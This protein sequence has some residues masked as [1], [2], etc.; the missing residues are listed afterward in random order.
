[1]GLKKAIRLVKKA[2]IL[3][4][5]CVFVINLYINH[6]ANNNLYELKGNI[7]KN[8]Y[9]LVL[10]T[11]KYVMGGGKNVYYNERIETAAGLYKS[12]KIDTII[13]SGDN[14]ESNYDE[15]ARMKASLVKLGVPENRIIE[16]ERGI[17]TLQSIRNFKATHPDKSVTIITQESHNQRAVYYAHKNHINAI[18]VNTSKTYF[19]DDTKMYLREL[20]AK[21]KAFMV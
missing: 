13:V 9:G 20:M 5:I 2:I 3:S 1:M 19:M 17:N 7:P 8:T 10:G 15:P 6:T 11:S 21:V 12:N 16:D 14:R 4:C 18:G